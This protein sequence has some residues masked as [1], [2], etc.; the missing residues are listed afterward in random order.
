MLRF[1]YAKTSGID[2]DLVGRHRSAGSRR[3][4]RGAR[5]PRGSAAHDARRGDVRGTV[6]A[7]RVWSG[8]TCHVRPPTTI[9]RGWSRASELESKAEAVQGPWSASDDCRRRKPR[10]SG[11]SLTDLVAQEG[12]AGLGGRFILTLAKRGG[13]P[14]PW[15]R[16]GVGTPIVLSPVGSGGSDRRQPRSGV[17]EPLRKR[18][19]G[20]A[21]QRT[22]GRRRGLGLSLGRRR[23]RGRPAAT[24]AGTRLRT[25]PAMLAATGLAHLR[26][27][28]PRR[29]RSGRSSAAAEQE[30][31][32]TPRS[33]S[34]SSRQRAS[35][36][37][38]P[39]SRSSTGRRALE[40]RRRSSRSYAAASAAA[41]RC[42]SAPRAIWQWTT[43]SSAC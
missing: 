22:A 36:C 39:T 17:C 29:A 13:R 19:C 15:T 5:F 37:L 35:H 40:R 14:L 28:A 24:A 21:V 3:D 18:T 25:C 12:H 33:T 9:S 7:E 26:A 38:R 2:A 1:V 8:G 43:C 10:K 32:S 42:S 11:N 16:I 31:R 6:G 20:V 27:V 4:R 41:R 30:S 34:L 23:G